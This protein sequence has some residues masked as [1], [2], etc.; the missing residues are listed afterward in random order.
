MKDDPSKVRASSDRE[1]EDRILLVDDDPHILAG[2]QRNLKGNY[3]VEIACVG[4][5]KIENSNG[6]F[7]CLIL[8]QK[9]LRHHGPPSPSR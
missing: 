4:G 2:S 5:N 9:V 6:Q 1:S 3:E 7:L 8:T